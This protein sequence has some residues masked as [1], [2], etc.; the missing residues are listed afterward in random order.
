MLS[1]TECAADI[2]VSEKTIGGST[3]SRLST[4]SACDAGETDNLKGEG[5]N[6]KINH[7]NESPILSQN[8]AWNE[9]PP[10]NISEQVH[11]T[12]YVGLSL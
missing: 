1:E 9:I 5:G 8:N 3:R 12:L 2:D 6:S 4:K 11:L 7:Y 10:K